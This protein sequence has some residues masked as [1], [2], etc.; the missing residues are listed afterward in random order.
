[1]RARNIKPGFWENEV[2]GRASHTDRLLFIG[3]WCLA[4]RDGKLEDRPDRIK[5][6]LFGYDR[7]PVDVEKSL[8]I[9][10]HMH[11]ITRYCV[12]DQHYIIIPNFKK[13]QYPN[14]HETKSKIPDPVMCTLMHVHDSECM[15][16]SLNTVSLNTDPP[17]IPQ[18][19]DCFDFEIL[20]ERYPKNAD[21]TRTGKKAALRY[22][23][24]SVK[25][26]EDYEAIQK[27]LD[28]YNAS[29]RV[30]RGFVQNGSTWFNNWR[31]WISVNG[32]ESWIEKATREAQEKTVK[33]HEAI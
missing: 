10:M 16:V 31:D 27:A 21:G 1:M 13:H 11:L 18:K 23:N 17:I 12:N 6:L 32:E 25:T 22:F 26:P 19:G 24:A 20:W 33:A 14:I 15:P 28:N 30:T 5:H 29:D 8:C 2:L 3:L 4:D 9:L 7:R